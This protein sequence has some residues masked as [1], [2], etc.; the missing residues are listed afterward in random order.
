MVYET[1]IYQMACEDEGTADVLF[2]HIEKQAGELALLFG[3]SCLPADL[4]I[5]IDILDEK[6]FEHEKSLHFGNSA[7][8]EIVAFS[9]VHIY[10]VSYRAI[11][12]QYT[13]EEYC[14]VILHEL[15]H[16]LQLISTRI[17][18]EQNA[19]LYEAVACYLAGQRADISYREKIHTPWDIF[20]KN[21]YATPECY[22]IAYHLG[23]TLMSGCAPGEAVARCSDI[24]HCE[25]IC[26][27]AYGDL[28]K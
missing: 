14:R 16:V 18:P 8:S 11:H 15:V 23:A 17:P 25:A 2:Y 10:A 27:E 24:L 9:M 13:P 6:A 19:W 28:F 4:K 3:I 22:S 26:A 7:G 1:D 21:F 12:D 20:K 5:H